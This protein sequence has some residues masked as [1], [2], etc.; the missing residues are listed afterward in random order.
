VISKGDQRFIV[1]FLSL[2]GLA[3]LYVVGRLIT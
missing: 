1:A 3:I 2:A